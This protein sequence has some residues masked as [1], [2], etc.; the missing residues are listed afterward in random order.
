MRLR[1]WII[2]PIMAA[3]AL[4]IPLGFSLAHDNPGLAQD[5]SDVGPIDQRCLR[6]HADSS[7]AT[8]FGDGTSRPVDFNYATFTTSVHGAD[9]PNLQVPLSCYDCHGDYRYPHDGEWATQRDFRLDLVQ[10]CQKCHTHEAQLQADSTH[11]RALAAGNPNAAIFEQYRE[12]VHGD[13]LLEQ[14]NPDVPTCI[15]CHGVHNIEDPTTALFRL[16]SPNICAKCHANDELMAAYGISTNV[17]DSYVSD[18]HGT[19]VTLFQNQAADAEVNKAVCFNCHGVHDIKSPDDP[20]STV[21]QEKLLVTC[22][23]CHPNATADFASAWLGH[24]EPDREKFPIVYYVNEFYK[25]FIPG[26]LGF[27]A[28]IVATDVYRKVRVRFFGGGGTDHAH[29][30]DKGE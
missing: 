7:A 29:T 15:N 30:E 20:E 6:C 27:M 17:F 18:F 23:K 21:I 1:G 22:Q 28:V 19:T 11:A 26:V 10:Q 8:T 5:D 13:A 9:N 2:V 4:L 14:A 25:Y 16:K 24:Y 12:S 3:L